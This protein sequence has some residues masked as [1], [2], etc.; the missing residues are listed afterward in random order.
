[1][2]LERIAVLIKFSV[3]NELPR[4]IYAHEKPIYELI[5]G[6]GN[7]KEDNTLDMPI[8]LGLVVH[9]DGDLKGEPVEVDPRAEYSRMM[10][11]LPRLKSEKET[12]HPVELVYRSPADIEDYLADRGKPV[13][14]KPASTSNDNTGTDTD[15]GSSGPKSEKD[16][17]KEIL[18]KRVLS[19]TL[20]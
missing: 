17:M 13:E 10:N 6:A 4:V 20:I 16:R 5:H 11:E 15:T 2:K 8:P 18:K 19:L 12:R 1:M 14:T 7:V 9:Q 3:M